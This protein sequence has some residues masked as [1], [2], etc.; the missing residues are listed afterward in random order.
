MLGARDRA[1]DFLAPGLA[2]FVYNYAMRRWKIALS[3]AIVGALAAPF[4][5]RAYKARPT[6]SVWVPLTSQEKETLASSLQSSN[7]CRRET[8]SI[9]VDFVCRREKEKFEQG[10]D[11]EYRSDWQK[12]FAMNVGVAAA[13]FVSVFGLTFL[14]SM[15]VRGVA[16]LIRRYWEWLS[17]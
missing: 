2:L 17:A 5:F 1:I 4:V 8:G 16:S 14:I 3:L 6:Y 12:Y 13:T 15:L 9:V 7:F 11:Y 10:G